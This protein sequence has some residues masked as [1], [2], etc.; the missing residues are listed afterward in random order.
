MS[1]ATVT[2]HPNI[3]MVKY[4][5]K[6][7]LNKNLPSVPSLSMTLS[8]FHTVTTV[9]WGSKSDQV[10]AQERP[11]AVD[12]AQRALDFLNHIDPG[13]PP[14][15]IH[16]SNNFPM[17][18]GL[19]SS[20]SGFA[21]LAL[22]GLAASG[23]QVSTTQASV[24]A[25]RGSGSACRSVFGGFVEWRLGSLEDGSDSHAI[26]VASADHWPLAMVVAVVSSQKKSIGSTQGMLKTQATSPLYPHFVDSAPHDVATAKA[27]ILN[28]DLSTLGQIMESS[29]FKMHATMHT[30]QPP[31]IYWQPG[32]TAC[33]QTVFALR[34]QGVEAW[35]TMDAGPNVK[36]LCR[37]AEQDTVRKALAPHAETTHILHPGPA[38]TVVTDG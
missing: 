5:G 7:D 25:R 12:F 16:T 13:R 28:K 33:I 29:T 26:P 6:R 4:W 18:A 31:I 8:G 3:A 17:A 27:A 30:T 22:A 34:K 23:R 11:A 32:T 10:F 15:E 38:P 9:H 37:Q 35:L 1:R 20:S 36:V 2:A 21:A 14:C 19:A 24:L